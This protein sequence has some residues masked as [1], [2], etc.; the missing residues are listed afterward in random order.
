MVGT[1][2][3]LNWIVGRR[4]S[5][6][7]DDQYVS[8]EADAFTRHDNLL[9]AGVNLI[10]ERG[11]FLRVTGSYVRQRFTDTPVTTLPRSN[12]ALADVLV[13]YEFARKRGRLTLQVGNA[14]NERFGTVLEGLSIDTFLPR[15]TAFLAMRWRLF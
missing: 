9:R 3:Y 2:A 15:R 5:V 7:A 6:F 10:H 14:F 8:F 4:V 1:S 12:V 13:G 11:I